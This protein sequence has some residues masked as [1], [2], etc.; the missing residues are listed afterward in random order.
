MRKNKIC[1]VKYGRMRLAIAVAITGVIVLCAIPGAAVIYSPEVS[2]RRLVERAKIYDG[3]V[4]T[5]KG[6]AV[7]AIMK[8][9]EYGW[10]NVNDG[11]NAIGIWC[12]TSGLEPVKFLG[13]YKTKGDILEVVGVFNRACQEHGG[14]LDIHAD[15]ITVK[16]RGHSVYE[17]VDL[18]KIRLIIILF[19]ATIAIAALFRKR[20]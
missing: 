18:D 19:L 13:S 6:E 17:K 12:K 11:Y 14:D 8:R 3:K 7:T 2:S 5:Y 15:T 4:I 1:T 10:V 9:G 16:K 20:I